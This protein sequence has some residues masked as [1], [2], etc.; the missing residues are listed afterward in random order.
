MSASTAT[1]G[2][3]ALGILVVAWFLGTTTLQRGG[4]RTPLARPSAAAQPDED[5]DAKREALRP[6]EAGEVR[7]PAPGTAA[8]ALDGPE[9]RAPDS[10]PAPAV[11]RAR[12]LDEDGLPLAGVRLWT[13]HDEELERAVS[14][15]DG[16]V[17]LRIR[18]QDSWRQ[19]SA[20]RGSRSRPWSR[21]ASARPTS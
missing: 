11:A 21:T 2:A 12:C 16:R 5:A 9:G 6:A 14:G 18:P 15:I 20:P 1:K 10:A 8:R 19:A 3:L 4:P 17:E 13:L 7:T